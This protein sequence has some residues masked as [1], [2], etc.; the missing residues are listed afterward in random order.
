MKTAMTRNSFSLVLLS[1][2]LLAGAGCD[3][4]RERQDFSRERE[5]SA[6]RAAIA[7]YRA[8]RLDAAAKGF[9][10]AIR[11]NP[12]NAS[13]RFQY[14]CLMQD[15]KKDYLEAACAYREYL[16]QQPESD[17]AKIARD[18]LALCEREL[19][20]ALAE[21]HGLL[22]D[23]ASA[24]E[25]AALKKD[26]SAAEARATSAEQQLA[27]VREKYRSLSGEHERLVAA[28]KGTGADE[29]L[30]RRTDMADI[31]ALLDEEDEE[32]PKGT[33]DTAREIAA[34]KAEEAEETS[35]GALLLP[36]QASDAKA[37]RDAAKAV[38]EEEAHAAAERAAAEKEKRPPTYVVQEGDTLYKIALR[39]Y[40]RVSAWRRIR[41][42]NKAI[43][44]NDGRVKAGQTITLP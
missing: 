38:R 19:A 7:D 25:I 39:F 35:G 22:G 24:K 23:D 15:A 32:A 3:G 28:V 13:A 4:L 12:A 36:K 44:S 8:G 40:G 27:D 10:K 21:K 18:R 42:A 14:A 11:K 5:D 31:K 16:M 1:A 34:L 33:D 30:A 43:I 17:K 9:A 26:L 6:Y 2:A 20:K 37:K 29:S 41:D